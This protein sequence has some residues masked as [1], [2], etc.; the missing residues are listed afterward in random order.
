MDKQTYLDHL[1]YAV[2]GKIA[3][4][5]YESYLTTEEKGLLEM[6]RSNPQENHLKCKSLL[7]WHFFGFLSRLVYFFDHFYG[8]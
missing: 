2:S 7:N 5:T 1:Q 4:I 8:I 3:P 6:L